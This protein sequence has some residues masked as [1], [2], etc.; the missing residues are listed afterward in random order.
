MGKY[1]DLKGQRFGR[2]VCIHT[3]GRYDK[4]RCVLWYCECDC[5][6]NTIIRSNSLLTGNTRSCGC[7]QREIARE[8]GKENF[9]HGLGCSRIY[10]SWAH[11]KERCHN[12]KCADYKNYG[13]R[14]I[15]LCDEWIEFKPFYNWAMDNGYQEDL[16]IERIDNNGN[17]EP[18][19]C[20]W[21][22][23]A[24]QNNNKRNNRV[25]LYKG[26]KRNLIEWARELGISCNTLQTLLSQGWSIENTFTT[27]VRRKT[28]ILVG[29]NYQNCKEI[30]H[31]IRS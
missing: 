28:T 11:M 1:R 22:T 5:G 3:A 23:R 19:N 12:Q 25:I 26:E 15:T 16:T 18:R 29:N 27:P 13:G 21:A 2:L 17:Y 14:G 20:T 6:T 24:V 7:L 4:G 9:K 10:K 8:K 30:T 31:P